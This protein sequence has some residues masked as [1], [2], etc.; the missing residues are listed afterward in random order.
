MYVACWSEGKDAASQVPQVNLGGGAYLLDVVIIDGPKDANLQQPGTF[1]QEVYWD[2]EGPLNG[3]FPGHTAGGPSPFKI[4]GQHQH[5]PTS[6]QV[7]GVKSHAN[8]IRGNLG[9]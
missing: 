9:K 5:R 3:S 2:M 8:M 7:Q 4:Q 1:L 6:Y